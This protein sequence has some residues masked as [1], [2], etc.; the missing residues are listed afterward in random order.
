MTPLYPIYQPVLL[1]NRT[2]SKTG[3]KVI[4][5][6]ISVNRESGMGKEKFTFT[7]FLLLSA[8]TSCRVD[9]E[10]GGNP[11]PETTGTPATADHPPMRPMYSACII[12]AMALSANGH[13]VV[14]A[15]F[16]YR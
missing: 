14:P 3:T 10:G 4:L 5:L 1:C 6:H 2:P 11:F 15:I 7:G 12:L 8:G 16:W 13:L 9:K